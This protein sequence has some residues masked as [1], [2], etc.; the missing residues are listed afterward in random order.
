MC[1]VFS[2]QNVRQPVEHLALEGDG[3]QHVVEG[4][5]PV[6][7]DQHEPVSLAVGVADLALV[8]L[9]R[10]P[11]GRLPE[12]V[13]E[14]RVECGGVHGGAIGPAEAKEARTLLDARRSGSGTEGGRQ[15]QERRVD[16]QDAVHVGR[17]V[18]R[19]RGP[20]HLHRA[21]RGW[22]PQ[23]AS[24][25]RATSSAASRSERPCRLSRRSSGQRSPARPSKRELQRRARVRRLEQVR[26][27]LEAR[28]PPPARRRWLDGEEHRGLRGL[29]RPPA[30]RCRATSRNSSWRTGGG[31]ELEQLRRT[32]ERLRAPSA[33]RARD[34]PAPQAVEGHER[35]EQA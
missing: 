24:S 8:V 6:G 1:F 25:V 14:L 32:G 13:R 18:R 26:P 29:A 10:A 5:E 28:A 19:A 11:G 34:A 3:G 31:L 16:A 9:A 15:V 17:R 35:D 27:R 33:E 7:G 30:R 4:G 12:R 23:W 20:V 22:M 2:N 21:R